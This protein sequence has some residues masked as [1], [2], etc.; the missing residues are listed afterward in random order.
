M[1]YNIHSADVINEYISKLKPISYNRFRW[2]RNFDTKT[3][4]FTHKATL[5]ERI[6]NE[7]FN[8]SQYFWQ[9]QHCEQ[10]INEKFNEYRGN[11]QK[12]LENHGVEFTRRKRL[13]E[14]FERDEQEKL[15]SL[16]ISFLKEFEITKEE[17]I[18]EIEKF[19][20]TLE[21]LYI[22]IRKRY[23]IRTKSINK[24]GRKPKQI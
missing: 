6:Q 24:R 13:W 7:E 10:T 4:P 11:I 18:Q 22:H 8:F 5:L 3:K 9:A 23:E 16:Q 2:W 15:K 14:D 20:D 12:L 1:L 21:N 19:G 17:Y